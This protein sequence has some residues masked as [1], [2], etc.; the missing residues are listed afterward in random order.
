MKINK[1]IQYLTEE[2]SI[3]VYQRY[4]SFQLTKKSCP[5][6]IITNILLLMTLIYIV[7]LLQAWNYSLLLNALFSTIGSISIWLFYY[8]KNNLKHILIILIITIF[9]SL[10]LNFTYPLLLSISFFCT[11]IGFLRITTTIALATIVAIGPYIGITIQISE[12]IIC[13]IF[14]LYASILTLINKNNIHKTKTTIFMFTPS[15]IFIICI[16]LTQTTLQPYFDEL[17]QVPVEIE[18]FIS[19]EIFNNESI[20]NANNGIINQGNIYP[21]QSEQLQISIN[22]LSNNTI[23]LRN[24]SG[25]TYQDEQWQRANESDFYT[26]RYSS[27]YYY[28]RQYNFLEST[29]LLPNNLINLKITHLANQNNNYFTPYLQK[30]INSD[31]QGYSYNIIEENDFKNQLSL[32][33]FEAYQWYQSTQQPYTNYV[34]NNYLSVNQERLPQLTNWINEHPVTNYEDV[35]ET[36]IDML[37]SHAT[38]S[39]TPGFTLDNQDIVETFLFNRGEGYCQHF[40][41]AATLMYRLYGIPARYATGYAVSSTD[42][43]QVND[44]YEA[45]ITNANAHAWVEIYDRDLGWI[46]IEVTPAIETTSS[47]IVQETVP[48]NYFWIIPVILVIIGILVSSILKIKRQPLSIATM[49]LNIIKSLHY[50]NYMTDYFGYEDDFMIELNKIIP[51]LSFEQ[52][53]KMSQIFFKARF[54]LH[55]I[56]ADEYEYVKKSFNEIITHLS[57]N[58]NIFKKIYLKLIKYF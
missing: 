5:L 29:N 12:L 18:Q 13:T 39:T 23:Y 17:L 47:N 30:Y 55:Q 32:S 25:G 21:N 22:R 46:P 31:A 20:N 16:F 14:C 52:L 40:A 34:Y 27:S 45:I 2:Y 41:S 26:Q 51:D 57:A 24:F 15:L 37:H 7:S 56:T 19:N 49:Y 53:N 50:L 58:A 28:T 38:Y 4:H 3:S 11:L 8:Y 43:T 42:F 10:L 54:S 35:T 44:R 33:D 36:I 6:A 1:L 9:I 48:Y